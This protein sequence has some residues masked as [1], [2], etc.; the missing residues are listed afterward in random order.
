MVTVIETE[1]TKTVLRWM[2]FNKVSQISKIL[3]RRYHLNK[4]SRTNKTLRSTM[5]QSTE[6]ETT[7]APVFGRGGVG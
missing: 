7:R 6:K 2:R 3:Q 1:C 5:G 4:T